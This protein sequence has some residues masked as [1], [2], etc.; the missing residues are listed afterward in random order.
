MIPL[1][2]ATL[3]VLRSKRRLHVARSPRRSYCRTLAPSSL[4]PHH[5]SLI[6]SLSPASRCKCRTCAQ[7]HW[8]QGLP[9][10]RARS[11]AAAVTDSEVGKAVLSIKNNPKRLTTQA[12]P[13]GG[14]QPVLAPS[15]AISLSSRPGCQWLRLSLWASARS[16]RCQ[17][18]GQPPRPLASAPAE[19]HAESRPAGTANWWLRRSVRHSRAGHGHGRWY[20]RSGSGSQPGATVAEAAATRSERTVSAKWTSPGLLAVI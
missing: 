4:S 13:S 18:R 9:V 5:E 19:W 17:A 12:S 20:G 16:Q 14:S 11:R 15:A 3:P 6:S 8:Q 1:R 10:K 7:W 2:G